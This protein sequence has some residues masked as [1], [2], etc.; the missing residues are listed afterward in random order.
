[1]GAARAD[2]QVI[3]YGNTP[4]SFANPEAD[5]SLNPAILYNEKTDKRSWTRC[6]TSSRRS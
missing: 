1:M 4:R 6:A 3:Q 2:W 5:G